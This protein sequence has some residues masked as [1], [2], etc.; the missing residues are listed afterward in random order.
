MLLRRRGRECTLG[1]HLLVRWLV[2][3]SKRGLSPVSRDGAEDRPGEDPWDESSRRGEALLMSLDFPS[4]SY[5]DGSPVSLSQLCTS[6]PSQAFGFVWNI[7]EF[8][9]N[10]LFILFF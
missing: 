2:G 9:E 8:Q 6:P 4:Y 5:S 3:A 7:L 10:C 1:V